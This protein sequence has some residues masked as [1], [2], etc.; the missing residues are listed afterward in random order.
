MVLKTV[1]DL[2]KTLLIAKKLIVWKAPIDNILIL[3]TLFQFAQIV[4]V[5]HRRMDEEIFEWESPADDDAMRGLLGRLTP[6]LVPSMQLDFI[7]SYPVHRASLIVI[8]NIIFDQ[9]IPNS[10]I[11]IIPDLVD[12]DE[13]DA[14]SPPV[15]GKSIFAELSNKYFPGSHIVSLG[16][17]DQLAVSDLI[18]VESILDGLVDAFNDKYVTS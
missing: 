9:L 14:T 15:L 1:D 8:R 18:K 7:Y 17:L 12:L 16:I 10:G 11:L 13:N 4:I 3:K 5:N 2:E 6:I